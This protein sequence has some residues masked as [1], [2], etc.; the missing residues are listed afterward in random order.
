MLTTEPRA[1]MT[2]CILNCSVS[3]DYLY[4]RN[5][6]L[7]KWNWGGGGSIAGQDNFFPDYDLS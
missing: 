7:Q 3:A 4:S 5:V 2:A 1:F 6:Q